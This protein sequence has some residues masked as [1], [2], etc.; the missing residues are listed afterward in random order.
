MIK[1]LNGKASHTFERTTPTD[2]GHFSSCFWLWIAKLHRLWTRNQNSGLLR[3]W[4]VTKFRPSWEPVSSVRP[5]IFSL[6]SATV[7]DHPWCDPPQLPKGKKTSPVNKAKFFPHRRWSIVGLKK[8]ATLPGEFYHLKT[9]FI[10][11]KTFEVK[12]LFTH[13]VAAEKLRITV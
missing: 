2:R 13:F 12:F 1:G 6:V 4:P 7:A 11:I 5:G 8:S 9:S 10:T 3:K